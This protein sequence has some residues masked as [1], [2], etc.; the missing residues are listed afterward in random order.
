MKRIFTIL[1]I[2]LINI[3]YAQ[4]KNS[5]VLNQIKEYNEARELRIE[6]FLQQNPKLEKSRFRVLQDVI[7]GK[8]IYV[9]NHNLKAARATRTNFLQVNGDLGLDLEGEG[10][11]IGIWEVG[12]HPLLNHFEFR[13]EE[14]IS[15]VTILDNVNQSS[16]HATHVAGTLAAKGLN[17]GA[18]GMATKAGLLAYDNIQDATEALLQ[19]R[20]ND[21]KFSNHSYGVPVRNLDG[22]EWYMGAYSNP[23]RLWDA[24]IKANPYYLMVVSAGNDGN[25]TYPGG[26]GTRLD[27]LTGNKN[28]KNNLVV[29]NV[30]SVELDDN[31]N[32]ISGS[33]NT[34]S[35]QGPTDDGR[36]KP[37]IAG[38]GTQI[39]STTN[40]SETSYGILTGTSMAAPNVTGSAVL[41]QELYEDLNNEFMLASTL[42]GLICTT[43][44]DAGQVGPDPVWGWGLMNSKK[45]AETILN[46]GTTSVIYEYNLQNEEILTFNVTKDELEN[47]KVGLIWTDED[48]TILEND[49][50]NPTPSLVNDI[51]LKVINTDEIEF[52]PWKL[53]LDNLSGGAIKGDNIV[54]NVEIVEIE[55][56]DNDVYTIEISHKGIL[57]EDGQM[58]SV[59]VTGINSTT[60]NSIDF[61]STEI[62]FWPNPVKDNLNISSKDISFTKDVQVSIYDMVGREV[63]KFEDLNAPNNL[64]LNLS[65]LSKGIYILNLNDGGQS[66]QKRII[67]E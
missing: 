32:F 41:L 48:G 24:V 28:S 35:S 29:A 33:I 45:A 55:S 39:I 47:L 30:S 65:P 12:G 31:G 20:D 27:K 2:I 58:V 25:V 38:L 22:L 34:G 66:I 4:D 51:D 1:F 57:D 6:N 19:A 9:E 36:I 13:D 26:L 46:E 49:I 67:K 8:P 54:D 50:N 63:L 43:A 53:D 52:L 59:I 21:L 37:D 15:K 11:D 44:D 10:F 61:N 62:T 42:K 60:L 64:N 7:N 56:G 5:I 14:G 16:L 40:V 17:S 18:R 3:G 23:A